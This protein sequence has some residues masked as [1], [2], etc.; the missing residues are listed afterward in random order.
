MSN[1]KV[2][3]VPADIRTIRYVSLIAGTLGA[4]FGEY[5]L[6]RQTGMANGWALS[7]PVALDAYAYVA[8]RTGARR[9][10]GF[11]LALMGASQAMTHLIEAH[12]IPVRWYII[13]AVWAI[14]LPVVIWR[15]HSTAH[16][17]PVAEVADTDETREW[18]GPGVAEVE[19]APVVE[20]VVIERAA[21]EAPRRNRTLAESAAILEAHEGKSVP[22]LAEIL[23]VSERR[24]N[25]IL[26]QLATV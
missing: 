7:Y 10:V 15:T 14:I 6:A 8:F 9:D 12:V 4:M 3:T 19:P 11:A 16:T 23:N 1:T 2:N 13:L 5:Q 26:R 20:P 25:Q 18:V 22:E 21:I 24:V 17:A